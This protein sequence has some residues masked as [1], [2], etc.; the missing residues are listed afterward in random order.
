MSVFEYN[1]DRH[2]AYILEKGRKEGRESMIPV[3]FEMLQKRGDSEEDAVSTICEMYGME[4]K[5]VRELLFP[6]Q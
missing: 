3:F 5:D 6:R 2:L 4:P 1:E